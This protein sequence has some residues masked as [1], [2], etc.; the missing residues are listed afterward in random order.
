M[1]ADD[2]YLKRNTPLTPNQFKLLQ[3][4]ESYVSENGCG[5]TYEEMRFFMG[6]KYVNGICRLVDA[7]DSRDWIRRKRGVA[8]SITL[9]RSIP[10]G[11]PQCPHCGGNL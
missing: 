1:N 10:K 3:Y 7:L 4:I 2:P 5:P 9:I 8:N 6:Y 11:F